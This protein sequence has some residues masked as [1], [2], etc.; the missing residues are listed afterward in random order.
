MGDMFL[1]IDFDQLKIE[2]QQ[3]QEKIE[4]RNDELLQLKVTAGNTIRILSNHK[5][6]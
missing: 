1:P 3:Y 4:E 5:V 2:N 6:H